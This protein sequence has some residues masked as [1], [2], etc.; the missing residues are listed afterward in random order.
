MKNQDYRN[1]EISHDLLEAINSFPLTR[2]VTHCG[3][4]FEAPPFDIYVVCPLC[5]VKIKVRDFSTHVE[6]ED[7]FDAIFYW[8]MQPGAVAVVKARQDAIK[9][10]EGE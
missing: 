9:E 4:T 7:I 2:E 1:L 6:V 8:M 5:Q 3:N 10:I